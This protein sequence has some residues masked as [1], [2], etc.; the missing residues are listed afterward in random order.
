M[1]I[2]TFEIANLSVSDQAFAEVADMDP[3]WFRYQ[4]HFDGVS[5]LGPAD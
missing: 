2:D 5:G 4:A 3:F 1:S